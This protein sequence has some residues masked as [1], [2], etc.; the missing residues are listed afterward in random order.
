MS[1]RARDTE[2]RI[3]KWDYIKLKSFCRTKEK[4]NKMKWEQT[5]WE[6]IFANNTLDNGLISQIYKELT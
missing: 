2:K 4:V 1:P 5:E 3:N 6:I